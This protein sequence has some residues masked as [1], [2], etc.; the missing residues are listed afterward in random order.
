M[1]FGLSLLLFTVACANPLTRNHDLS[2][3]DWIV[4]TH[5]EVTLAALGLAVRARSARS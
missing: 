1:K 5:A 4:D 3:A 2:A